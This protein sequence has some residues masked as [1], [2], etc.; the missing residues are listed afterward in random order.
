[1][2][3]S[4]NRQELQTIGI[5]GGR[6]K[7]EK[8]KFVFLKDLEPQMALNVCVNSG[9]LQCYENSMSCHENST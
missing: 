2:G 4:R 7:H 8:R 5:N 3:K 6:K 1:M 9:E